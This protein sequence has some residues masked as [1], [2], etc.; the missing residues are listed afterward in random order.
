MPDQPLQLIVIVDT[1]PSP[2]KKQANPDTG[3]G[4]GTLFITLAIGTLWQN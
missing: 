2:L 3:D 1:T 4:P